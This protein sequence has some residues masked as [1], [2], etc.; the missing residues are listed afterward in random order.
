[1]LRRYSQEPYRIIKKG[2]IVGVT[3]FGKG[4]MQ[5]VFDL[6]DGTSVKITT[7]QWF[8]PDGRN[9]QG[10]GIKPDVEVEYDRSNEEADNQ[11]QAAIENVKQKTGQ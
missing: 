4:V 11:L 7:D 1:M 5:N 3:T 2:D 8:T 6:K 9:V 10:Q